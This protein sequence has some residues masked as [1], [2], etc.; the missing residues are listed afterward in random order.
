MRSNIVGIG[1]SKHLFSVF[2]NYV[3]AQMYRFYTLIADISPQKLNRHRFIYL[4]VLRSQSTYVQLH[5]LNLNGSIIDNYD[6]KN[7][8]NKSHFLKEKSCF[9]DVYFLLKHTHKHTR[10]RTHARARAH[11]YMQAYINTHTHTDTHTT[12]HTYIRAPRARTHLKEWQF[13]YTKWNRSRS[14][15]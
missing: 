14:S 13:V 7:L 4:F 1:Y 9:Q 10:A 5:S 15:L 3:Q 11:T 2:H 12:V 6:T 8:K